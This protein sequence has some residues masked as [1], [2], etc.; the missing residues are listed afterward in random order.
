MLKEKAVFCLQ[1]FGLCPAHYL[2][3]HVHVFLYMLNFVTL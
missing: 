3:P 1:D 2:G